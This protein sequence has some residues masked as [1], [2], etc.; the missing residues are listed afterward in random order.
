MYEIQF[1]KK[2]GGTSRI[3]VWGCDLEKAKSFIEDF[4]YNITEINKHNFFKWFFYAYI[5]DPHKR[6]KLWWG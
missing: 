2:T 4:G 1:L 5:R 6:Y 3:Y